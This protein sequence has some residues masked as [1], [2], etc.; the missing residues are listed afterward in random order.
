MHEKR[1]WGLGIPELKDLNLCV[2]GSWVRKYIT[3]IK[4]CFGGRSIVD[5]KYCSK[6]NIFT[7]T[8]HKHP[9]FERE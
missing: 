6:G 3:D 4:A 1:F 2:L 8:K 7:L 5:K 9:Y